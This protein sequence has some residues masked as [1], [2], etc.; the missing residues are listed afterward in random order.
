M[1]DAQAIVKDF[2]DKEINELDSGLQKLRE[3]DT[4]GS[5]TG[6]MY[7]G[8]LKHMVTFERQHMERLREELLNAL[9]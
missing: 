6:E 5:K 7:N 2:M 3:H 9:N 8:M 1:N 4:T